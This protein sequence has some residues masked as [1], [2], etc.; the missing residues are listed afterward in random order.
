MR[1]LLLRETVQDVTLT[2][3]RVHEMHR[4]L[5]QV[6]DAVEDDEDLVLI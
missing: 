4:S 6:A 3:P 5:T 2:I 1:L